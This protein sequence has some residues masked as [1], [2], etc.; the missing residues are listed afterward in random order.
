MWK[1]LGAGAQRGAEIVAVGLLTA[2]FAFFIVQIASRY[3]F[4]HPLG[5][6]AEAC[7]IAW[8]WLV[9]WGAGLIIPNKE[10]VRFDSFTVKAS[11]RGRR[12]A[13]IISCIFIVVTFVWSL[14]ATIDYVQFMRI[15]RSGT[16]R[17]PL[18]YVFSV[19]I[20]FAAGV[21][22]RQSWYIWKFLRGADPETI[23]P[24]GSAAEIREV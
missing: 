24:P 5:W 12:I 8:V 16:L 2:L 7:L 11:P 14:P 19:F 10:H 20:L 6:T 9:F 22:V 18:N 17:I 15:E 3:V 1:R 23:D 21:I 4:N 13:A